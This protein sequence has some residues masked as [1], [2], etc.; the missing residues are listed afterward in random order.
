MTKAEIDFQLIPPGMHRQNATECAIA[1]LCM[2][3]PNFPLFLWD[4]LVQQANITLNLLRASPLNPKLSAYAQLH[5]NFDF[6]WMPLAPPGT[7]VVH[8]K[9]DKRKSWDP[10]GNTSWYTGPVMEHYRCYRIL[11]GW[12]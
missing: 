10:H 11:L 9:P 7:R 8:I 3:D 1:G 4:T 12:F 6:N 5:G 2:A